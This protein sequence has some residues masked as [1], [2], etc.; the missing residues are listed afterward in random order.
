MSL[1]LATFN[2][3][4][5]A[6][7]RR[8][9]TLNLIEEIIT[10][11]P[12]ILALQEVT[13]DVFN[14]LINSKLKNIYYFPKP[15]VKPYQTIT[16]VN[17]KFNIKQHVKYFLES[18]MSRTLEVITLDDYI[19]GNFHLESVFPSKNKFIKTNTKIKQSQ[20]KK[21][22]E[23]MENLN[24]HKQDYKTKDY[25]LILMGDTN[26]TNWESD[27]MSV[28]KTPPKW[29]DLYLEF[30]SP[31]SLKYTYDYTQND[32]VKFKGKSRFDRIYMTNISNY[33]LKTFSFLGKEPDEKG[34]YIS[35]HFGIIIELDLIERFK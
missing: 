17:K 9:R 16:I 22:F 13:I 28:Y 26:I 12:D 20:F 8:Q 35:D 1:T 7:D 15:E 2:L 19:I 30:G 34:I 25:T 33:N 6:Q 23:I 18:G 21:I 27:H 32:N 31:L 5:D 11:L 4:F 24:A 3:W 29:N 14:L 10:N